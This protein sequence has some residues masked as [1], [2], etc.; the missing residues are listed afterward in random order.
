MSAIKGSPRLQT[1]AEPMA[2]PGAQPEA[3]A[4]AAATAATVPLAETVEAAPRKVRFSPRR[5][6]QRRRRRKASTQQHVLCSPP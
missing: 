3:A 1:T 6:P 2:A 5:C 4:R